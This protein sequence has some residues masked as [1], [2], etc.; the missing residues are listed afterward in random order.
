M[1]ALGMGGAFVIS[2]A[3]ESS[4]KDNH[5]V[6]FQNNSLDTIDKLPPGVT[7]G[8]FLYFPKTK[9]P[10]SITIVTETRPGH[11][12]KKIIPLKKK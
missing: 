6:A 7:L 11:F 9:K 2:E 1:A 12:E 10:T 5:F 8:G 3:L 4:A